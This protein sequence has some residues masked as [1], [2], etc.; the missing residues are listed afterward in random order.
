MESL[1]SR[2]VFLK[3]RALTETKGPNLTHTPHDHRL[4]ALIPWSADSPGFAAQ[5][6]LLKE[7]QV[8]DRVSGF[9]GLHWIYLLQAT[10]PAPPDRC[11]LVPASSKQ[12]RQAS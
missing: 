10:H 12:N 4:A 2:F 8:L 5:L 9:P 6:L 7:N 1:V 11:I 3:T